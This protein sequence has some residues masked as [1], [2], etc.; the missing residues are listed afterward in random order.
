[1]D[2]RRQVQV[3]NIVTLVDLSTVRMLCRGFFYG[4][5]DGVEIGYHSKSNVAVIIYLL[6]NHLD[7]DARTFHKRVKI[8]IGKKENK[9]I[10]HQ[11]Q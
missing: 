5:D 4:C 2:H 3:I 7:M 6:T 9:C 8:Y 1:M 11:Q 10:W